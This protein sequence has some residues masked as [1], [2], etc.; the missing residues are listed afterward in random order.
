MWTIST[1]LF[2]GDVRLSNVNG[3]YECVAFIHT[4]EVIGAAEN[5]AVVFI[6]CGNGVKAAGVAI[7]GGQTQSIS[8]T[9]SASFVDFY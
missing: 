6:I 1:N 2:R 8:I 4:E 3:G 5:V 9:A 7:I